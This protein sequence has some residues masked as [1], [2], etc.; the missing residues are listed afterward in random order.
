M[1]DI[2]KYYP[3]RQKFT[4]N[5]MDPA[6]KDPTREIA[7]IGEQSQIAGDLAAQNLSGPALASVLA[8]IQA[9]AGTQVSDAL[10]QIQSDNITTYNTAE[11]FNAGVQTNTDVL[12]QDAAKIYMDAVNLVDQNYDNAKNELNME[13]ADAHANAWTNRANTYNLNTLTPNYNIRPSDGGSI[14]ITDPKDFYANQPSNPDDAMD[15]RLKL[16]DRCLAKCQGP[17]ST[18]DQQTSCMTD[19]QQM[20]ENIMKGQ[21]NTNTSANSGNPIIGGYPGNNSNIKVNENLE[22]N[23]KESQYGSELRRELRM[24][25]GGQWW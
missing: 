9:T 6:Y 4:G 22:E 20:V 17:T 23:E 11:Q 15:T 2:N 25:R 10:N 13:I 21:S 18:P 14:H 19:C 1:T 16:L 5:F 7:A 12:N 8:K 24:R 3:S